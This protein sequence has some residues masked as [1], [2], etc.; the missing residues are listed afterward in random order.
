M[1]QNQ[2]LNLLPGNGSLKQELL[3]YVYNVVEDE[4]SF[5][6]YLSNPRNKL[7][8]IERCEDTTDCYFLSMATEPEFVFIS[9]K[10]ISKS[11][12]QY[13]KDL[14][15]FRDAVII[16]PERKTHLISE[17]LI[18]DTKAISQLVEKAKSYKRI[19]LISYSVTEQF[20]KL[21]DTLI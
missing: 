5:I 11:F 2:V 17:D 4:W 20:Y 8:E 19:T 21:K 13:A 16:N 9:P 3:V 7:K 12:Q 10:P 15:G 1:N 14:L 6:N 18:S